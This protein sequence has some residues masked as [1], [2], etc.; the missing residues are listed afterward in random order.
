M[1]EETEAQ[2][3][4]SNLPKALSLGAGDL[5]SQIS[6]SPKSVFDRDYYAVPHSFQAERKGGPHV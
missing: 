2:S 1:D 6:G 5:N 3:V 4:L